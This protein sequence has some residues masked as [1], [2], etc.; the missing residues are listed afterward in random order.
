[1]SRLVLHP[2]CFPIDIPINDPFFRRHNQR[3]MNFVRS[4]PGPNQECSFGYG[5]QMNQI[6][7]LHDASNVYG[8]D[9]EENRELREY[10]GG[11]LRTYSRG[12]A[13]EKGLLPQE[14]GE[15]EAEE[16]EIPSFKQ[17]SQD[18]RCFKAGDSRSNEQP[19]LT[20]YHTVWMREHNRQVELRIHLTKDYIAHCRL[21]RELA[22]LN[23]HW[24]DEQLYQEARRILI[25]EMQ[26]RCFTLKIRL[27]PTC[28]S[29]STSPTTSGCLW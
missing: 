1:M 7:H 13:A 10:R 12:G 18:R 3:C 29:S 5:E 16:C 11:L 25:A 17:R 15:A 28:I 14:E 24:E 21:A 6:T 20:A 9:E 4:M 23:P 26:V 22:Y 2:E 27:R 8:S 19:G